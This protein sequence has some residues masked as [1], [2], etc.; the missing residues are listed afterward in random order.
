MR[1]FGVLTEPENP[2]TPKYTGIFKTRRENH[3]LIKILTFATLNFI[4]FSPFL[5]ELNLSTQ[6]GAFL[7]DFSEQRTYVISSEKQ[8]SPK[9]TVYFWGKCAHKQKSER[10]R[11]R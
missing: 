9:D 4:K 7:F 11:L 6:A 2:C 8:G 10:Y 1:L 5:G 3:N